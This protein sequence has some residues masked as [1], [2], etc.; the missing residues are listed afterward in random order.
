MWRGKDQVRCRGTRESI[1]SSKKDPMLADWVSIQDMGGDF[2]NSLYPQKF[3][4]LDYHKFSMSYMTIFAR[5][6]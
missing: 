6:D 4:T 3:Q 5:Y 2:L 1:Y